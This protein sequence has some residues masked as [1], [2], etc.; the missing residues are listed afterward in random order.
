MTGC[1]AQAVV[2][3]SECDRGSW[4]IPGGLAK[5]MIRDGKVCPWSAYA[6]MAKSL[7]K[8]NW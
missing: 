5:S 7:V 8:G 3:T 6:V 2:A 4:L 1:F